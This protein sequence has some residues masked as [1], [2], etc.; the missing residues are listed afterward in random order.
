MPP[1]MP[2]CSILIAVDGEAGLKGLENGTVKPGMVLFVEA[3]YALAFKLMSESFV[4]YE[5]YWPGEP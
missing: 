2:T 1:P 5:A 4:A 3:N